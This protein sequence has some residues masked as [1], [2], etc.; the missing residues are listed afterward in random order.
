MPEP[1][2]DTMSTLLIAL[3]AAILALACLKGMR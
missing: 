1:E 2:P 3:C